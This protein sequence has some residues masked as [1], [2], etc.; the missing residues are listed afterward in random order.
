M[1]A[2][3]SI[4]TRTIISGKPPSRQVKKKPIVDT[5]AIKEAMESAH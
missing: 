4:T 2:G 3:L 5:K 1:W